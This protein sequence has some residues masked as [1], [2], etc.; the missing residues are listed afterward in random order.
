MKRTD[1][2]ILAYREAACTAIEK[3]G[4]QILLGFDPYTHTVPTKA[5][6]LRISIGDD[7]CICTR[8]DN[9][10]AAR[11]LALGDRLNPHSG[12]WNW[13]GGMDHQ[14]DMVDMAYFQQAL[15]KIV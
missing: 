12:K 4:G 11:E 1:R 9:S 3:L 15:R 14:G 13:M 10:E 2:E 6:V 5:G 8:F 7:C